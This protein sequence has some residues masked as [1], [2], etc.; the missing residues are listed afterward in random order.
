MLTRYLC[1]RVANQFALTGKIL[2][3]AHLQLNIF[4]KRGFTL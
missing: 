2:D 4:G 3:V 1:F